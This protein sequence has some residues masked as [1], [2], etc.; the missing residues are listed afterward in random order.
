MTLLNCC[1]SS[2]MIKKTLVVSGIV[3]MRQLL[4]NV[5]SFLVRQF[6]NPKLTSTSTV[7]K[8]ATQRYLI[9]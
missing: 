4:L 5:C 8:K 2:K 9:Q 6:L 1:I 7:E 3:D